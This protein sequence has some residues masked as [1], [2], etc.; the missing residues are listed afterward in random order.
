MAGAGTNARKQLVDAVSTLY[1]RAIDRVLSTPQ[2]VTSAA[3][4]KALLASQERSETVADQVQRVVLASLPIIRLVS[5]GARF[6]GVPMAFA[7]STAFSVSTTV[8][9]GVRETQL[10]ASLVAHRLEQATGRPADPLLV[11]KLTVELYVAPKRKPDLSSRRL[12]LGRLLRRWVFRG[13]FGRDTGRAA[14]RA[15]D[16][17]EKLDV[18][19]YVARWSSSSSSRE[20]PR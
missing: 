10:L 14:R 4:A 19:P 15:F 2:R 18:G 1:D 3:E 5:R 16:A 11:K 13:A 17:A 9:T 20:A 8:R 6:A 7:A 12:H